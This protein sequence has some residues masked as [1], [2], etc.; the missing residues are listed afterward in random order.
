MSISASITD[1][2][3][4]IKTEKSVNAADVTRQMIIN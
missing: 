1:T 3:G 2:Y 4:I